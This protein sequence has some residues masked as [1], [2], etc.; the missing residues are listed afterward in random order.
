MNE[1]AHER[2]LKMAEKAKLLQALNEGNVEL[3]IGADFDEATLTDQS[4]QTA[5]RRSAERVVSHRPN[6]RATI[7]KAIDSGVRCDIWTAARAGLLDEVRTKID[8]DRGLLD[9]KDDSG[10][11]PLQ[12]A[13]LIYGICN[14]C[15][16]VVN[17]LLESGANVDIF[18]ACTYGM[19]DVVRAELNRDPTL[20]SQ[21]CEGSTP[22]N[23]AVRPRRNYDAA[24]KICRL[25]LDAHADVHDADEYEC[26]MTSL[27][28]AAEW[29]PKVCLQLVDLLLEA[30]ADINAKDGQ[31]GWT[32]LQYA[33]DRGRKEMIEH[34]TNLGA[35]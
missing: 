30:G 4:V 18:T 22:L 13:A 31:D 20:V 11:T 9:A 12:R 14:E 5:L 19:P 8:T 32:P 25:L 3:L 33:K 7:Q 2:V 15:E 26:D 16:Q 1:L 21:R 24:P 23:W 28:H 29:G 34:L 10:R 27:H 35:T 17:F 6:F